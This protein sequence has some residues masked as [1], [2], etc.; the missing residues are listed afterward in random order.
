MTLAYDDDPDPELHSYTHLYA[1]RRRRGPA[2]R[3]TGPQ[4]PRG[5]DQRLT[6]SVMGTTSRITCAW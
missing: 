4:A 2:L 5:P 6:P 1:D 3:G